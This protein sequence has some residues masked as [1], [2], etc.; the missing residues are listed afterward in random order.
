MDELKV[1]AEEK[2]IWGCFILKTTSEI[3][4]IFQKAGFS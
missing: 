3:F 4:L 1:R 2:N